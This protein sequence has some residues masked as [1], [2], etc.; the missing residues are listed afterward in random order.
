MAGITLK[1]GIDDKDFTELIRNLKSLNHGRLRTALKA[2]GN[3]VHKEAMEAFEN[4]RSPGGEG[5]DKSDRA[6]EEGGQTLSDTGRLK[7]SVSVSAGADSVE[8][9]TNAIYAAIH[10][11]GGD[12]KPKKGRALKFNGIM[13]SK[14]T[15][16]ARPFLPDED[17]MPMDLGQEMLAILTDHIRRAVA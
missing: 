13:R 14:V 8:V 6:E 5:W 2:M 17:N 10:Q 12:I 9:G 15:M 1:T 11:F 4:E 3:A 16:P 7:S